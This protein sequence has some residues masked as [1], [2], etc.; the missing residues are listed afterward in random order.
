ME[1][2]K[3]ISFSIH[4]D[5]DRKKIWEVLWNPNTYQKWTSVFAEGSHYKGE[6]K[7]GNTIQFLGKDGGGMSSYIE[8]RIENEQMVFAHQ[9]EVKNGVETD[10]KWQGAKEI[11][12]LKKETDTS[13]ELQVIMDVLPD[14]EHYFKKTFPNAL[15]LVRQLSEQ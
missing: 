9:K 10:S 6:L 7:Q 5:S 11:Y 3:T 15:A 2:L 13:S 1:I 12:Y 8:K 14:M 4:I